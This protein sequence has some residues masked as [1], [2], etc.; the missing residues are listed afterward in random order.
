MTEPFNACVIRSMRRDDLS[1][2]VELLM[3]TSVLDIRPRLRDRLTTIEP[4]QVNVALVAEQGGIVVGA[5]KLTTEPAF[6]GTVSA[7]VAV[8]EPARGRGI[9]A[10][11]ANTLAARFNRAGEARSVTCAIRD[12]LDQ[13]RQFAERFGFAVTN[14]SVGWRIDLSGNPRELA[15]RAARAV[16]AAQVQLRTADL[17]AEQ[18]T[19]MD[20]VRRSIA[21]LPVPRGNVQGFDPGQ[22]SHLIPDGSR[23]VLA[24]ARDEPGHVCGV[25]ILAPETTSG[26]WH[27]NFTGVDPLYRDR[28]V[29]AAL[30][31][32]SL[33]TGWQAGARF[34]TAVND[35]SNMAIQHLNRD[36]GMKRAVGYWSMALVA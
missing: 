19:I 4:E 11:L 17:A 28:G 35:D 16:E 9:G 18:R 3:Q 8:A 36:L 22:D 2:V 27:I 32:A 13:G 34:I 30:K 33:L 31:T 24:E 5:A 7:L 20:C 15:T 1:L 29:A 26:S 12:D 21:G 25:T 23:I 14:H 6:P 10:S